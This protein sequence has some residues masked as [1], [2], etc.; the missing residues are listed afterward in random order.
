[1]SANRFECTALVL[2]MGL[3]TQAISAESEIRLGID[4]CEPSALLAAAC[5]MQHPGCLW[6]GDNEANGNLFRVDDP[7]AAS[8]AVERI[9]LKDAGGSIV[10]V[11]DIEAMA[12]LASRKILVVGSHGH[13]SDCSV[14]PLRQRFGILDLATS[15]TQI[16]E[17]QPGSDK[18]WSCST[19]MAKVSGASAKHFCHIVETGNTEAK[20]IAGSDVKKKAKKEACE[21]LETFNIEGA[22]ADL[23]SSVW[24]GIRAPLLPRTS[25]N[26]D[27]SDA[28]LLR[29]QPMDWTSASGVSF[30]ALRRLD[31][32]GRG[33]R[34]LTTSRHWL[35]IVA[36]PALDSTEVFSLY[37]L[38][39]ADLESGSE[40]LRPEKVRD[41]E[42]SS[43]GFALVGESAYSAIDGNNKDPSCTTHKHLRKLE[44]PAD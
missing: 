14:E 44:W 16:F 6:L 35:W 36:G 1:M 21:K 31:L 43:E 37:R 42:T 30:D 19:A 9:N 5:P 39:W 38:S 32:G 25:A 2:L 27:T 10:E 15:I 3:S 8:P 22:A 7:V 17:S 34:E 18:P 23:Q 33:V 11:G 40:L 13:K 24:L 28:V 12:A 20:N 26:N 41:L 29:A 4:E